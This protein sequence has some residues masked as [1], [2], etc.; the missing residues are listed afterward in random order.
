M[1]LGTTSA[2]SALANIFALPGSREDIACCYVNDPFSCFSAVLGIGQITMQWVCFLV[3]YVIYLRERP[4]LKLIRLLLFIIY[5]PR[6][7]PFIPPEDIK[8]KPSY[9]T[10]LTVTFVAIG[11]A[12]ALAIITIAIGAGA[13]QYLQAYANALG[14]C[15]AV[16]TSIQY[17]PQLWT[18]WKLGR[19]GSISIP[20]M[21]IQTPGGF[22]WAASLSARLGWDGWS[23]WGIYLITATM[24]GVLL[25]MGIIFELQH[26][27]HKRQGLVTDSETTSASGDSINEEHVLPNETAPLLKAKNNH[28]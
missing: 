18:T 16:L 25:V 7:T 5:F 19:I 26:R 12:I 14:I 15:A 11:H 9:R 27:R 1:L 3:M 2:S 22:L 28:S 23:A 8:A 10:A 20:M 17:F 4:P 24:Q 6:A 13:P 21:C